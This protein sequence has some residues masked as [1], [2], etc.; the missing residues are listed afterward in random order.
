MMRLV[1]AGLARQGIALP[2]PTPPGARVPRPHKRDVLA[3][4]LS[5]HGPVAILSIA[6]AARHMP[7]EPVVQALLGAR[8]T[9]DL[10]DRWHRLEHFSHGRHTVET[11]ALGDGSFRLSHRARDGGPPPSF[12]ESLLVL[13]VLTILAEMIGAADATLASE[14]GEIWRADGVWHA[15]SGPDSIGSLILSAPTR[16]I[17]RHSADAAGADP[18]DGLRRRLA[19]DPVRR[20]TLADLAAEARTSPRTLQRRLARESLS[21]S[22]LVSE[23][24]LQIAA[25]HLCDAGGPGLAEIGFLAGFSDQAHFARTFR[26]NVGTTPKSYRAEFGRPEGMGFEHL[27]TEHF[28]KAELPLRIP[29]SA[30]DVISAVQLLPTGRAGSMHSPSSE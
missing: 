27:C 4:I 23:S 15:P 21:F 5:A 18:I 6:Y 13:G 19:A 12:G 14:A 20:W 9:A 25:T 11:Q 17:P 30:A 1:A 8:D 10:L 16:P 28:T 29:S 24:R 22:R 3:A 7:P 2:G 26:R